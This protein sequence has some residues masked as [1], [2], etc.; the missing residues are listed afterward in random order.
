MPS[1]RE[2]LSNRAGYLP[3]L[4]V[5]NIVLLR[6]FLAIQYLGR[7]GDLLTLRREFLGTYRGIP[8]GSELFLLF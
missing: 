3:D 5:Y 2:G 4:T 8:F 6:Q 1:Q 7:C